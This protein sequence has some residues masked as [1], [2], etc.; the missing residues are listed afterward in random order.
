MNALVEL[1]LALIDLI[2]AELKHA[3]QTWFRLG[4]A[5]ALVGVAAVLLT[6]A[7]GFVLASVLIGLRSLGVDLGLSAFLTGLLALVLA[8]SVFMVATI[9]GRQ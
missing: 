1:V 2:K 7:L 3:R 9:K 8:G 4:L 5:L 6:V